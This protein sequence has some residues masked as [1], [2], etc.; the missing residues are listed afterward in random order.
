MNEAL[1]FSRHGVACGGD[2]P[3]RAHGPAGERAVSVRRP[4]CCG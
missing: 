3:A 1:R 4:T 2:E